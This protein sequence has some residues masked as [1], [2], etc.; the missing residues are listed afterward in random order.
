MRGT[1]RLDFSFKTTLPQSKLKSQ[2]LKEA[3]KQGY[4]FVYIV[5][6]LYDNTLQNIS[7][8]SDNKGTPVLELYRVDVRTGK[9]TPISNGCMD[10]CNFF[11]LNQIAAASKEN[12]AYPVMMQVPG[13]KGSRDFPFAGVPT[14]IV[15]PEGILLD[16]VFI[17]Q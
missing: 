3:K 11:L 15:A 4:S 8:L 16:R 2:L 7:G 5:R 9:E 10:Y 14:C 6:R 13:A 12:S 1:S 17:A